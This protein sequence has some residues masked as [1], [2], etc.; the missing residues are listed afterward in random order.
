MIDA[1]G[2]HVIARGEEWAL[3]P[4]AFVDGARDGR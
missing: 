4:G 1:T 2:T 3:R